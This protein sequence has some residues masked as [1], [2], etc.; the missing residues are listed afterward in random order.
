MPQ[1]ELPSKLTQQHEPEFAKRPER[2][3][4]RPVGF[5]SL[6]RSHRT[7][8]RTSSICS[9]DVQVHVAAVHGEARDVE[10]ALPA[11]DIVRALG[12]GITANH[13]EMPA[14]RTQTRSERM[15]R[16]G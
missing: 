4:F 6:A 15:C 8:A 12:I 11:K 2:V 10:H 14:R 3:W 13:T 1:R 9:Q 5:E 7:A 16:G